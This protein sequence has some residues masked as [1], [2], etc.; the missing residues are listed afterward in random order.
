MIE[1]VRSQVDGTNYDRGSLESLR[2]TVENLTVV[3][4]RI[5]EVLCGHVRSHGL[6]AERVDA[7]L[8]QILDFRLILSG[9]IA[10]EETLNNVQLL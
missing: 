2:A 3:V 8:A 4:S 6:P 1:F 10:L 5:L 7:V 9:G